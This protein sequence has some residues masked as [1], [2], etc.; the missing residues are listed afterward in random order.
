MPSSEDVSQSQAKVPAA[1]VLV[2]PLSRRVAELAREGRRL[3]DS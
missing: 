2:G 3:S 1:K